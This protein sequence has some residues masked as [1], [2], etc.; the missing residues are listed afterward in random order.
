MNA[1]G[2]DY[3]RLRRDMREEAM[4]AAFMGG[5]GGGLSQAGEIDRLSPEEL[6]E[7]AQ[8]MGIRLSRYMK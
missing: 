1:G 6:V 4:G 7:K 2:I 8:R 3:E 5:F